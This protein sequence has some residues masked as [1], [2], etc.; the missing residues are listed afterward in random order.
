[1][2]K[3]IRA[4]ADR[5]LSV[6]HDQAK[7]FDITLPPPYRLG[8][9]A[10]FHFATVDGGKWAAEHSTEK[11]PPTPEELKAMRFEKQD[12]Y[13]DGEYYVCGIVEYGATKNEV[14]LLSIGPCDSAPRDYIEAKNVKSPHDLYMLTKLVNE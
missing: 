10:G 12:E 3:R 8:F 9:Y 4:C 5:V 1:M 7:D 11:R 2:K 13:D 6:L 14:H